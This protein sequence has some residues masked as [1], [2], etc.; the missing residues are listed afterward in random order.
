LYEHNIFLEAVFDVNDAALYQEL[1][2]EKYDLFICAA[3]PQI[4]SKNLLEIPERGVINFHP[5]VLPRCRGAHPHYWALSE[6]E[7]FGGIT[8]HF[9][10][11]KI[12]DGDI[13]A[14]TKFPIS[15]Y[16]VK[17]CKRS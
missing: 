17:D 3:Y 2:K 1:K 5:S 11:E 16:T 6:G 9:M 8:A 13:I 10:T 12:D 7:R 4:L 14:Q 15:Q